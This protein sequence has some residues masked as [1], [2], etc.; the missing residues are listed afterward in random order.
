MSVFGNEI[1]ALGLK[2]QIV[3]AA[4]AQLTTQ[5]GIVRNL[6]NFSSNLIQKKINMFVILDMCTCDLKVMNI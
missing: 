4:K 3:L 5:V 2:A 6:D 1:H